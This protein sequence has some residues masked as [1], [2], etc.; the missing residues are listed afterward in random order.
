M[1]IIC[2]VQVQEPD[3]DTIEEQRRQSEATQV[4]TYSHEE[5]NA[6]AE[7]AVVSEHGQA[8]EPFVRDGSKVGRNDPCPCGSGK[9]YKHCHGKLD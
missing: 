7:D 4:R 1:S 5:T 6:L 3:I 8:V 2:R 9:K